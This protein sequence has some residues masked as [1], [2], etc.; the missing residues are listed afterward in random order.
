VALAISMRRGVRLDR[1]ASSGY[2]PQDS[3][4]FLCPVQLDH[5]LVE[6]RVDVRSTPAGLRRAPQRRI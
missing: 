2:L 3:M 6:R 1:V 4:V 5:A